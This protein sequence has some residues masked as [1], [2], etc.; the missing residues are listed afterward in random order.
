MPTVPVLVV[1]DRSEIRQALIGLLEHAGYSP[2]GA[3]SCA[4][5]RELV[6]Q[7]RFKVILLDLK[8]PDG[9]GLD[10][11]AELRTL[12]P[13]SAVVII[14]GDSAVMEEDQLGGC[15]AIGFLSK[16]FSYAQLDTMLRRVLDQGH[17]AESRPRS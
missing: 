8:L 9:S 10:F 6:G 3:S 15:Q 2:R 5:A 14:S 12:A 17:G 7:L 13:Q 11:C 16:P 1:E 4:E